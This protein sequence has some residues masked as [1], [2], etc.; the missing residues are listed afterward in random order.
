[1]RRLLLL[2]VVGALTGCASAGGS[3]EA[4]FIDMMGGS[5]ASEATR[6]AARL[7]GQ[8]LGSADNPIRTYMPEGQRA[9]LAR[10]R[11]ANGQAPAANRI[12][13][14]GAGPY[15][16]IVDAYRVTCA[17]STPAA[18]ELHMD[19]YHPTYTENAAPPGFNIVP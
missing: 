15:G 18:S 8:P 9:Y 1:M 10:L 13:S 19:M 16:S 3:E 6:I 7:Q 11:C 4:S 12:G 5:S 14:M 17:G 2:C